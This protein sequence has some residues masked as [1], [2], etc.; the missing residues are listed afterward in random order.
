[1]MD[2]TTEEQQNVR[3]ALRYLRTRAG[4]WEVLSKALG[5]Q[6]KSLKNVAM[7]QMA[8]VSLA[9]RLGRLAQVSTDDVIA[10][11]YPAAGACPYCGHVPPEGSAI[12]PAAR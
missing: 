3:R 4:G 10:G 5:F 12:T 2:L 9:F 8:S 11:R 6:A 1:M 7:G